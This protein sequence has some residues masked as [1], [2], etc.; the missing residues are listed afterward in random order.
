MENDNE[1]SSYYSSIPKREQSNADSNIYPIIQG[2]NQGLKS[3][4]GGEF[5][6]MSTYNDDPE[7]ERPPVSGAREISET[8]G[9]DPDVLEIKVSHPGTKKELFTSKS[10][11]N[12]VQKVRHKK[13]PS[14]AESEPRN[15]RD[16]L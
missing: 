4:D 16:D 10:Q 5:K 3:N 6:I 2:L 15:N 14:N 8:L 1:E 9:S 12:S 7:P 11:A 13:N